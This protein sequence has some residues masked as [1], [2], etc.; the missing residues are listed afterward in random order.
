MGCHGRDTKDAFGGC[1][2]T[3]GRASELLRQA[4]YSMG[5]VWASAD[6]QIEK[7]PNEFG[8]EGHQVRDIG[9]L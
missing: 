5:N 7:F 6:G 2:E 8:V 9:Q 3:Q 1:K 4:L